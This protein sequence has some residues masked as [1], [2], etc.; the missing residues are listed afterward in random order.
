MLL[1]GSTVKSGEE[2]VIILEMENELVAIMVDQVV[3][4]M[5]INEDKSIEK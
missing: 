3:E 4:V 1:G 2:S 5:D